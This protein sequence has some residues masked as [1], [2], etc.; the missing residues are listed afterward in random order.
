MPNIALRAFVT[1][2]GL[3]GP[4]MAQERV[5]ISCDWGEVTAE[6]VDSDA[7]RPLVFSKLG[8]RRSSA[9]CSRHP[10]RPF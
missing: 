3:I 5:L 2:L 1:T 4:A 8:R 7:T 6:L 9:H 10:Q